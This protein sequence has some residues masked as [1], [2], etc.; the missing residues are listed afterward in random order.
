[1]SAPTTAVP[2]ALSRARALELVRLATLAPSGHN[3]Q[4]W[5]F[6]V[7]EDA[8]VLSTRPLPAAP[9][10]TPTTTRSS[11]ASVPPWRTS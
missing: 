9:S 1:M 8:V 3:T 11:S 6:D 7:R 5:L 4:P 10:S 2:A